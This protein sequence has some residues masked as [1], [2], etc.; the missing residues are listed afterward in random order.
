MELVIYVFGG[1][2]ILVSMMF[3]LSIRHEKKLDRIEEFATTYIIDTV[4]KYNQYELCEIESQKQADDFT[5]KIFK[6]TITYL[7]DELSSKD[8]DTFICNRGLEFKYKIYNIIASRVIYK[9]EERY[10]IKR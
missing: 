7:R 4:L 5:E 6:L 3:Y 1:S 8:V 2:F 9:L 10:Y